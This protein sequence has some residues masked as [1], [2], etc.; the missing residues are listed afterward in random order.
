MLV[1]GIGPATY[2]R[3]AALITV[4]AQPPVERDAAPFP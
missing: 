2:E 1:P 3:V 4:D